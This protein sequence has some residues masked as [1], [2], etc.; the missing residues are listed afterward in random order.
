MNH[1]RLNVYH[2]YMYL[3]YKFVNNYLHHFYSIHLFVLNGFLI[4]IKIRMINNINKNKSPNV[5]HIVAYF[6][7]Y[8]VLQTIICSFFLIPYIYLC[9][10]AF[11]ILHWHFLLCEGVRCGC[12]VQI[13]CCSHLSFNVY[14]DFQFVF[15]FIFLSHVFIAIIVCYVPWIWINRKLH[16]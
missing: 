7:P 1:I 16:F 3:F 8:T 12:A 2:T 13:S 10:K 6:V 11:N 4:N 9:S 15:I 14:Y 5:C